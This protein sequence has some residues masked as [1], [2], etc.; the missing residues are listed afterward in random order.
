[1]F[2]VQYFKSTEKMLK[3]MYLHHSKL[4]SL[5]LHLSLSFSLSRQTGM[6]LS[7]YLWTEIYVDTLS[8]T[9][10]LRAFPT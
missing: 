10:T 5:S 6:S 8:L 9:H 1:M 3:K 2:T 4:H 7:L